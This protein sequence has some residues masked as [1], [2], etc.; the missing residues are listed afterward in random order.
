MIA[1]RRDN[2]LRNGRRRRG[3]GEG[4]IYQRAD[5]TWCGTYSAGYNANGKRIRRT[6]FGETKEDVAGKMARVQT[7]KLDGTLTETSKLRLSAYLDRWLEDASRPT[8]RKT[9]HANYKSVIEN[10]INTRI[11]GI[12]LQKLNAAHVQGLYAEMERDKVSAHVR[13]MTHAVLRRALKQAVKWG[14]AIR[15]VCDAVDPP[16][17]P[18]RTITP[19][20]AEQ[21]HKL[22]KAAEKDRF[23]ALY[24]L[25]VGSGLRLGEIFGLQWQH[26]D[27][28]AQT[29]NVCQSLQELNGKLEL[30][31]PKTAK[32]RRRVDLPKSV[33]EALWKHKKR[34]LAEGHAAVPWVFCNG[35]GGPLRRSHFHRENFKPLLKKAQL[36]AIRFHDLRHTSAT[37]LLSAGVHP[38]VVQERLGHSQIS[39]TLDIYSHVLPTMQVEAAGRMDQLLK[40]PSLPIRRAK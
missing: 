1:K 4:S 15:N 22:L 26:V 12:M 16:R 10:H 19:L 17:T 24:V 6:V 18:K 9:T 29:L 20:T 8:I 34:M 33:V 32:S 11:G 36:P 40:A 39:V 7:S 25:A 30:C 38:K 27:L 2:S 14:L 13:R 31:E 28:K 35:H 23:H 3:R 21:V 37:L 5:G